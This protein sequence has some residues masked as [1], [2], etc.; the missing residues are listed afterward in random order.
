MSIEEFDYSDTSDRWLLDLSSKLAEPFCTA[1]SYFR[2]RLFAPL[3]GEKFSNRASRIEEIAFRGLLLAGGL[4]GAATCFMTPQCLFPLFT[5]GVG[6][7]A[8]RA[9][10]FFVQKNNFTHVQGNLPEKKL[11]GQLKLMTWNICGI[12][13][14]MH[15]DHGGVTGWNNR[16]DRIVQ[17]IREEDADVLV[18]QEIYDTSLAEAVISKLKNEYAHFY[19]HLGPNALGSVGGCMVL[20]KHA[21]HNFSHTSFKNNDWTMNRGFASLEL[22]NRGDKEAT[23]RVIGTHLIHGTDKE[24]RNVQVQQIVDSLSKKTLMPT[25]LMGDLNIERDN[26]DAHLLDQHFNHTYNENEP[27]CTN[28]LTH[29][30]DP[31]HDPQ[32][33][34][35]IDYISLF[36]GAP[37]LKFKDC[38]LVRAFDNT[39]NTKTALS[40]HHGL[41][42]T[43]LLPR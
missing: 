36:K 35:L 8:F 38:H 2:Y 43:F 4:I 13:G 32:E 19:F 37:Q 34:E 41:A 10:G 29:Q 23:V 33:E 15:Y 6:S 17:K 39:Y 5:L 14:G 1:F 3:D 27:T 24:R 40:D 30:W 7:R 11:D 42:T 31:A 22:K 9:L 16:I 12:G 21:V 20:S 26:G 25:L 18:L 28:R